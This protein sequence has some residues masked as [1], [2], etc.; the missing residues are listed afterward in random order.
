[1]VDIYFNQL[2]A[3]LLPILMAPVDYS[4]A[5]FFAFAI[6]IYHLARPRSRCSVA[7]NQLNITLFDCRIL[8]FG[9]VIPLRKIL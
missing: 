8:I 9:F 3:L 1:V 2:F 5:L 6:V 7:L 4:A